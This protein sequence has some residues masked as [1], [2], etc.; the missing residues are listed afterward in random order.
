M[1][2]VKAPSIPSVIIQRSG[3]KYAHVMVYKNKWIDGRCR[4]V[5]SRKVGKI[6]GGIEAI[7]NGKIIWD[8]SFIT[9]YPQLRSFDTW[10]HRGKLEFRPKE[11]ELK[12]EKPK[13]QEGIS[14]HAGATW[15]LECLAAQSNIGKALSSVFSKYHSDLKLLSVAFYMVLNSTNTIHGYGPFAE[16][17]KLPWGGVL[18]DSSISR[19]FQSI[20]ETDVD[21]FFKKLNSL[22]AKELE[23]KDSERVFLA[24]DS[25]S[26]STHS[27]ELSL[28]QFGHN[29]DGDALRQLNVL[30]LVDQATGIPLFYR[31]YNGSTPDVSTVRRMIADS[32]ILNGPLSKCVLVADRGYPSDDNISDCLRNNIHFLF[33]VP[34]TPAYFKSYVD[35]SLEA[36]SDANNYNDYIGQFYT[37][38]EA[39]FRYDEFEVS[40][41]RSKKDSSARLFMHIYYDPSIYEDA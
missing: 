22:N 37:T 3:K 15:A 32:S 34:S 17:T 9:L 29:K 5:E 19:L 27:K 12:V 30:F 26:I 40:G 20:D 11:D 1:A 39:D 28:A 18:N 2:V 35:E 41:K 25:I 33:R 14:L 24:L 23:S 38:V 10:H 13:R 8:E 21:A 36:L 16:T 31:V 7:N 6:E 4:R